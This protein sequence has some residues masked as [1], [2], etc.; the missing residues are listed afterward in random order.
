MYHAFVWFILQKFIMLQTVTLRESDSATQ[1]DIH[2]YNRL[3]HYGK[4]IKKSNEYVKEKIMITMLFVNELCPFR[5]IYE[6][7][8]V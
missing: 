3:K 5:Q 8:H 1:Q 4:Q 6:K 7:T 2:T